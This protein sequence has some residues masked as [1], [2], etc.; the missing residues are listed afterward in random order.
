MTCKSAKKWYLMRMCINWLC[1][2]KCCLSQSFSLVGRIWSRIKVHNFDW[3]WFLPLVFIQFE[4][5]KLLFHAYIFIDF[6][7][8]L[9][10]AGRI[11]PLMRLSI[12]FDLF[13]SVL[14]AVFLFSLLPLNNPLIEV[15]G[16]YAGV[17]RGARPFIPHHKRLLNRE[18]HSFPK[19]KYIIIHH[20]NR[21]VSSL[22]WF[23]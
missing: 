21:N 3:F 13:W 17:F 5:M 11:W 18:Q 7:W 20:V 22:K 9:F 2:F 1:P 19:L 6:L 16:S 12:F 14:R 10:L 23:T 15:L 4:A 8:L